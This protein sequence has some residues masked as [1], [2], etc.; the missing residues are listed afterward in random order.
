MSKVLG[1]KHVLLSEIWCWKKIADPEARWYGSGDGLE[2]YQAIFSLRR[3]HSPHRQ[4][5]V[6]HHFAVCQPPTNDEKERKPQTRKKQ[7]WLSTHRDCLSGPS[8]CVC[9]VRYR[10]FTHTCVS[11]TCWHSRGRSICGTRYELRPWL[12]IM[13]MV[14]TS[15]THSDLYVHCS[16]GDYL[17]S[18]GFVRSLTARCIPPAGRHTA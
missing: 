16:S 12:N 8:P 5:V 11:S 15:H 6:I 9:S 13:L 10:G 7:R 1:G 2:Y 3:T 14:D 17:T 18:R 4:G